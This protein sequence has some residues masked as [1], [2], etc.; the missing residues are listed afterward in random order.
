MYFTINFKKIE[1]RRVLG[2]NCRLFFSNGYR[3]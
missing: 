3:P 2:K 1:F